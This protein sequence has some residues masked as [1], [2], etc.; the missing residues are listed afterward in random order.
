MSQAISHSQAPALSLQVTGHNYYGMTVFKIEG[1]EYAVGTVEQTELAVRAVAKEYLDLIDTDLLLEYSELPPCAKGLVKFIQEGWWESFDMLREVIPDI[2]A[3]VEA[4]IAT[5][6]KAP[7]LSSLN[8]DGVEHSLADFP[9]YQNLILQGL[10]L[11]PQQG[12]AVCL[13][14]L[15]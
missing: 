12:N 7:F 10:G 5:Q 9:R 8:A 1:K 14:R 2:D 4:A 13:Y 15:T 11:S 3:L 6:G